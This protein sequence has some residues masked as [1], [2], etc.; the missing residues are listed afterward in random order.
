MFDL[1]SAGRRHPF[2]DHTVAPAAVSL[3]VHGA[4]FLAIVVL[5]MLYA[6]DQL[7]TAPT[8]MAF[9]AAPVASPP[10]PPPPPSNTWTAQ[11]KPR[12]VAKTAG[13][14]AAPLEAPPDIRPE[15]AG[16]FSDDEF[17]VE[18][19]IEGGIIGGVAGGLVGG[20]VGVPALQPPPPPPPPAPPKPVRIG[21]QLK[22]PALIHRVEP[23]YPDIAVIAKVSGVVILEAVVGADGS[24]ESVHVLRSVKF[25]D[26]A[27]IEAVQQWRY[28]PLVLNGIPTPFILTVT[29]SFIFK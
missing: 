13:F 15:P 8:I 22:A 5:P 3:I 19:G 25:L 6:T 4:M 29:L 21:G 16:E 20:L 10:P 14:A 17:G 11:G 2:H 1:I 28:S 12:P 24:V 26:A 23:K 18:G 27:A 7:P 9:V